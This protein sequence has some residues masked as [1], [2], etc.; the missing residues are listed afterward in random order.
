MF[1]QYV[2]PL[3]QA[4]STK[5]GIFPA[6]STVSFLV[7]LFM[8]LFMHGTAN[9]ADVYYAQAAGGAGGGSSCTD[10]KALPISSWTAGNTYHLCGTITSA[11]TV[12]A[13]GSSGSPITLQWEPNTSLAV[14]STSGAL[15]IGGRSNLV[16][17]LGGNSAAITCPNN[18][19]ALSS[20]IDAVAITDAG[21]G[22]TNVEI[23]NGTIGP[24][25]V[26]TDTGNT[27]FNSSCIQGTTNVSSSHIHHINFKGCAN[28][29]EYSMGPSSSTNDE[30][31]HNTA[32]GSVGRFIDY[33]NGVDATYTSTNAKIH[34]NDVNYSSVWGVPAGYQHYEIIHVFNRGSGSSSDK[35]T[36]LQ[37]Y[38]NYFHGQVPV[39]GTTAGIFI[40]EG[41]SSCD[42]AS[43]TSVKIFNNLFVNTPGGGAWSAGSG[44]FI[45]DQDCEHTIEVYNNTIDGGDNTVNSCFEIGAAGSGVGAAWTVYNNICQN[46]QFAFAY[47]TN[48]S[49]T[50]VSNNNLFY[51]IKSSGWGGWQWKGNTGNTS[52]A[53][54]KSVT[55]QDATSSNGTAPGLSPNYTISGTS[56]LAHTMSGVDLTS[57]NTSS[58]NTGAPL[59]FGVSGA[60]GAGCVARVADGSWDLGAYAFGQSGPAPN[61]VVLTL[62]G[63]Q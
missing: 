45:Y 40:G 11:I 52:F 63:V 36:N 21:S 35:I 53:N 60:C 57:L 4:S 42:P 17:D 30:F 27:G 56:S 2:T 50:L 16:I 41:L 19:N 47:P 9:A 34:D 25:F 5:A 22:W 44:G 33:A 55:G 23:R 26:K 46:I 20:T 29:I 43:F 38:N 6:A 8:L 31:D 28:T 13:S 15:R 32:D 54:W 58:L 14:C 48:G 18:G 39:G 24:M 3:S 37:I 51:N 49:A 7:F 12:G 1:P 59:S 10:A 61:P 62:V